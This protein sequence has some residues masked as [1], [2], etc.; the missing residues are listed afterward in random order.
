MLDMP[1]LKGT[2]QLPPPAPPME[3][4]PGMD[5]PTPDSSYG[6]GG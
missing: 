2:K 1:I 4:A 6:P 5:T 3:I